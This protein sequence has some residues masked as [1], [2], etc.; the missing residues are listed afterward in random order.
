MKKFGRPK[1]IVTD[2]LCSYPEAM[3]DIASPVDK[4]LVV[5]STIGQRI[6]ISRFEGESGPCSGF[7]A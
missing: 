2:G 4:K 6:P 7:A 1:T 5:G 3:K